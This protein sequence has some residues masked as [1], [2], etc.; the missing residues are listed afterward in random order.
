MEYDRSHTYRRVFD[1]EKQKAVT[2]MAGQQAQEKFRKMI[3][4]LSGRLETSDCESI[5]YLAGLPSSECSTGKTNFP[6]HV[7]SSLE[8]NGHISPWDV[9]M[10]SEIHHE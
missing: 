7:L 5:S 3:F 2:G 8:G 1:L 10:L 4:T 9:E 6:L